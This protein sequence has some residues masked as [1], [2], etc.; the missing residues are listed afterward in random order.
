[1]PKVPLTKSKAVAQI[2]EFRIQPK[3]TAPEREGVVDSTKVTIIRQ[4]IAGAA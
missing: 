1:M 3:K 2:A 4:M